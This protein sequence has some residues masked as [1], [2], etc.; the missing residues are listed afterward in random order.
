MRK[1][2][3]MITPCLHEPCLL[4]QLLLRPFLFTETGFFAPVEPYPKV[5]DVEG[6][7]AQAGFG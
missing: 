1:L 2:D 7:L 3:H 6:T 5:R 4:F